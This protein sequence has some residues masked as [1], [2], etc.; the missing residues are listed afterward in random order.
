MAWSEDK[1]RAIGDDL[2]H[3]KNLVSDVIDAIER[4][5]DAP[6]VSGICLLHT[7]RV[8]RDAIETLRMRLDA[9]A[10]RE[11]GDAAEEWYYRR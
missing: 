10:H 2:A 1:H 6:V 11:H 8:A 9:L 5:Y 4:D 7:A 3:A